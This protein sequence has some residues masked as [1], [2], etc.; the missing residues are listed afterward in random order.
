MDIETARD[1]AES[2]LNRYITMLHE[3]EQRLLHM[4]D[5]LNRLALAED[6]SKKKDEVILELRHKIAQM[7]MK[8]AVSTFVSVS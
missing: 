8:T 3:K 4:G 2:G 5:E 1:N 6:E 7:E